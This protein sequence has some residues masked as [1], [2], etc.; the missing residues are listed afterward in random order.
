MTARSASFRV[1]LRTCVT[2]DGRVSPRLFR[3]LP[4][5]RHRP[6]GGRSRSP[7]SLLLGACGRNCGGA[8][9]THACCD[10]RS[11]SPHAGGFVNV[12]SQLHKRPRRTIPSGRRLAQ[13]TSCSQ[14]KPSACPGHWPW[15]KSPK[16]VNVLLRDV[17]EEF[18]DSLHVRDKGS[19][20]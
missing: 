7:T 5:W 12:S 8:V 17:E 13:S 4:G 9:G 10:L 6:T 18:L 16:A 11:S 2:E 15:E 19:N 3:D 1:P 14:K 20:C